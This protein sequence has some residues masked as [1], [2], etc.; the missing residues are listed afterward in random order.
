MDK[1]ILAAASSDL[2]IRTRST[3]EGPAGRGAAVE[4]DAEMRPEG[5]VDGP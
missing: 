2:Q 3:I 5:G 4:L 1:S